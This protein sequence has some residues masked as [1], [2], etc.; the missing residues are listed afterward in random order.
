MTTVC[1]NGDNIAPVVSA[2]AATVWIL[3]LGWGMMIGFPDSD[4]PAIAS[5][6]QRKTAPDPMPFLQ[7]QVTDI[8]HQSST[9]TGWKGIK[10]TRTTQ[11]AHTHT[12]T[13]V[14]VHTHGHMHLHADASAHTRASALTHA[15]THK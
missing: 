10:T 13:H 5:T 8:R 1:E 14:H 12:H 15:H 3:S 7:H 2:L 9:T 11:C 6:P 4:P